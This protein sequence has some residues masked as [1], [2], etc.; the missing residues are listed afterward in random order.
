MIKKILQS[1]EQRKSIKNQ[2]AAI[3]ELD[4]NTSVLQFKVQLK[5][6]GSPVWRRI[7]IPDNWSFAGLHAVIQAAFEWRDL[8]P[9]NFVFGG[10]VRIESAKEL[11][12]LTDTNPDIEMKSEDMTEVAEVFAV[13][14]RGIYTYDFNEN[15]EHDVIFERVLP[16]EKSVIYPCCIKAKGAAP[17]DDSF[18]PIEPD[19]VQINIRLALL[20]PRSR[21][22][23]YMNPYEWRLGS[24]LTRQRMLSL[25]A[26]GR[27]HKTRNWSKMNKDELI[28]SLKSDIISSVAEF[29]QLDEKN[30]VSDIQLLAYLLANHKT[31]LPFETESYQACFKTNRDIG[32][33]IDKLKKRGMIFELVDLDRN[34]L[35]AAI[36]KNP[37]DF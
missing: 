32:K 37:D 15:W 11:E 35:P 10:K 17:S 33:M 25:R 23:Q 13:Y 27:F 12:I 6:T 16:L 19:I 34:Q 22:F 20:V 21:H 26:I 7:L 24:C 18:E 30:E 5:H 29:V 1:A 28:N 31:E 2:T 4:N 14:D 8:R 3:E 9:H 36:R